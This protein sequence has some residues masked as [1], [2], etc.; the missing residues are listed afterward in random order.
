M[1][2]ILIIA[3]PQAAGKTTVINKLIS[4]PYN[5][6]DLFPRQDPPLLFPLQES[7]QIIVHKDVLLGA[8]FMT[9]EQELQVIECDLRR[10]DLI[11]Q[12]NHKPAVYVDEC[13]IFTI[14]HALAHGVTQVQD[15]WDQYVTRLKELTARVIFVDVP[16]EV[17]WERRRRRYEQ[18]LIYFAESEHKAIMDNYRDYLFKLYPLLHQVF[19]CLPFP[20]DTVSGQ[21]SEENV[22][23]AV[24]QKFAM[25]S[26]GTV[27]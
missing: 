18:R 16:P 22:L 9:A 19:N 2:S 14:A 5:V 1:S 15:Y 26:N 23:K 12:R 24:C 17:S 3:G 27:A 8:I 6:A 4:Q 25:F 20:K 10:M 21:M 13:N 11:Q 7:R